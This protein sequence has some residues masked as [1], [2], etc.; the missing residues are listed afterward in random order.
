MRVTTI[1]SIPHTFRL[2]LSLVCVGQLFEPPRDEDG[3]KASNSG[4][5][6]LP[7][8]SASSNG[9]YMLPRQQPQLQQEVIITLV[10]QQAAALAVLT[11]QVGRLVGVGGR[12]APYA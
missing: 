12:Y 4:A 1:L 9:L 8:R 5:P 7:R 2:C 6:G 3:D 11:E 10:R